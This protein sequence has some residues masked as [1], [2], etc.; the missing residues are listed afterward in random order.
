MTVLDKEIRNLW[1]AAPQLGISQAVRVGDKVEIGLLR[2][3]TRRDR[4]TQLRW[5][6]PKAS[7]VEGLASPDNVVRIWVSALARRGALAVATFRL[8]AAQIA[9]A[10]PASLSA[11][12]T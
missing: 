3:A 11:G 6:D 7:L 5:H 4:G 1:P 12:V 10:R 2:D 8:R 9:P